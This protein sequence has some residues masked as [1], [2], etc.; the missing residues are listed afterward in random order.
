MKYQSNNPKRRIAKRGVY[1]ALELE[2]FASAAVY[3]G[4]SHH[5]LRPADYGF[6]PP[7]APRPSKSVCDGK[8]PVLRGEATTLLQAGMRRGMVSGHVERGW[9]KYVWALDDAGEVYEAKLGHDGAR[10]HGYRL[11][12]DDGAM[13]RWVLAEW[14]KRASNRGSSVRPNAGR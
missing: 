11:A 2:R 12:E 3:A 9:P 4:S 10:Y 13:R 8:R 7:V 1:T 5:K 6:D 14:A